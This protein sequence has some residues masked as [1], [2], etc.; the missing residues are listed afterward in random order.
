MMWIVCDQVLM[1]VCVINITDVTVYY[2]LNNMVCIL[3]G[4]P[5]YTGQVSASPEFI[6][7]VWQVNI[8]ISST[9]YHTV[10]FGSP[11]KLG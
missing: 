5:S 4:L 9:L 10:S 8:C 6:A 1:N 7:I 3:Y 11:V 2:I